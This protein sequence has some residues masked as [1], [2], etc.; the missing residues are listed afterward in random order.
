M[1]TD[2][3]VSVFRKDDE[4]DKADHR[5]ISILPWCH[6]GEVVIS[7]KKEFGFDFHSSFFGFEIVTSSK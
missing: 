5:A 7:E 4:T 3:I 1:K 2:S 6:S